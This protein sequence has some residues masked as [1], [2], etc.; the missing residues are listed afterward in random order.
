[1]VAVVVDVPDWDEV[2]DALLEWL[3]GTHQW[4]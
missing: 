2:V 1:M 4:R 3:G